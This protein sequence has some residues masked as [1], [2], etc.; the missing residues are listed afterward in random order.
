MSRSALESFSRYDEGVIL[1]FVGFFMIGLDSFRSFIRN[2]K[3]GCYNR[4]L[5]D[6]K[7]NA[8]TDVVCKYLMFGLERQCS[9]FEY[10]GA[11]A[12]AE[13]IKVWSGTRIAQR[14][15]LFMLSVYEKIFVESEDVAFLIDIGCG[16]GK[17]ISLL[18]KENSRFIINKN[19]LLVDNN[20]ELV[21]IAYDEVEKTGVILASVGKVVLDINN[22]C[23]SDFLSSNE[24]AIINAG[25]VMHEFPVDRK[26]EIISGL[27][28]DNILL[29]ISELC[30]DHEVQSFEA[31]SENTY[32]FYSFLINEVLGSS[33]CEYDAE[34]FIVDYLMRELFLINISCYEQRT[35]YHMT[36]S[37]WVSLFKDL[38]LNYSF[39]VATLAP[40]APEFSTFYVKK[41]NG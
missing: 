18:I 9:F 5:N 16:D 20:P 41:C 13:A 17:F 11:K 33:I 40:S 21:N 7:K 30:S 31:L 38:G 24:Y 8:T 39:K 25:S 27:V 3:A 29:V 36:S 32:S 34:R 2:Y 10:I 28:K 15:Y 35:N 23:A 1:V 12:E 37:Q 4:A 19:I 26:R 14:E 22:F 6:L